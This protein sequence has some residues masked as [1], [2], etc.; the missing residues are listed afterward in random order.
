M[1][2]AMGEATSAPPSSESPKIVL[3]ESRSEARRNNDAGDGLRGSLIDVLRGLES[4]WVRGFAGGKREAERRARAHFEEDC[5][6][7]GQLHE[8][9]CQVEELPLPSPPCPR[10]PAGLSHLILPVLPVPP[11]PNISTS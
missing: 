2:T 11:P 7:H 8:R 4:G 3:R 9:S 10:I 1:D 5:V 6:M